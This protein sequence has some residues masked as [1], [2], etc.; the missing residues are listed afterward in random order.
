MEIIQVNVYHET[1][2]IMVT[3]VF[4]VCDHYGINHT[5]QQNKALVV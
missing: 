1:E 3:M 5:Q 4:S 2:S